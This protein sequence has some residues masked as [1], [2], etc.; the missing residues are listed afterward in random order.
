MRQRR[1]SAVLAGWLQ[2]FPAQH[3]GNRY[4]RLDAAQF[5]GLWA[6]VMRKNEMVPV[7]SRKAGE[8]LLKREFPCDADVAGR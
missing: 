4:G 8:R 6:G 5:S 1:S 7:L 3:C 2:G